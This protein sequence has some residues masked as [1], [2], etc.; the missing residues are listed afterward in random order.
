MRRTRCCEGSRYTPVVAS[1]ISLNAP[2]PIHVTTDAHGIPASVTHGGRTVAVA[3]ILDTWRID[4]EWWRD[5]ISR[6]YFRLALADETT[7]TVFED[8]VRGGWFR[9]RYP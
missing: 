6:R 1:L 5:E 9:Q 7:I 2:Q 4:D 8:L 3:A